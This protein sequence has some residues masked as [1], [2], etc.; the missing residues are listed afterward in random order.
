MNTMSHTKRIY[1]NPRLKKTPRSHI[2][3]DEY[4]PRGIPLT[5]RSWIC[6]GKC[7]RCRDKKKEPRA[8]R[9]KNKEAFRL[10]ITHEELK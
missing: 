9:N 10:Q 4:I 8:I 2:D 7:P 5:Y 1:N 3:D 6:M